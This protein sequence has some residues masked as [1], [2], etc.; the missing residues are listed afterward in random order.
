MDRKE[1]H[2]FLV[3]KVKEQYS[4]EELHNLGRSMSALGLVPDGT[5]LLKVIV[6]MYNE[7][8][9]AFYVPENRSLYSFKDSAFKGNL[10]KMLLC[11]ELVHAL[12]DQNYDLTTFPLKDKLN[13]DLVL[14]TSA[15]IEGDATVVMSQWLVQHADPAS[16]MQD[17]AGMFGQGTE[18]LMKAP[19]YLREML[20]FPYMQ[21]QAFVMA[22][23]EKGG[24]KAVDAAFR[25]PPKSTREIL[26][27]EEYLGERK[28]PVE[29]TL[30]ELKA[31]GWKQIGNNVLGEFGLRCLFQEHVGPW[32]GQVAAAGWRG[33]RFQVY[34][35][36]KTGPTG[37]VWITEWEGE[38]DAEEFEEAYQALIKARSKS[39]PWKANIIR[40]GN[41]VAIRQSTDPGFLT[42]P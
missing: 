25:N 10:D 33:D 32:R 22:L 20:L 24:M 28:P 42:I 39:T 35:K 30:P 2:D 12:Q 14:A 3:G 9:A 18:E 40:T 23:T 17:M 26:H 8:V 27:P 11:H 5:D 29:I 19:A 31:E 4:D 16:L 21:G 37:I 34:E 15:L 6:S 1:L 38:I 13:D 7:Q 36:G 41:R